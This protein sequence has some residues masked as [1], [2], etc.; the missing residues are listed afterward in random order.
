MRPAA[1]WRGNRPLAAP[2]FIAAR[3]IACSEP[4]AQLD[5]AAHEKRTKT[6]INFVTV[7]LTHKHPN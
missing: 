7:V 4:F 1:N 5:E 3:S 6:I 2:D